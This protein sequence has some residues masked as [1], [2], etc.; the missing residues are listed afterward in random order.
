VYA[1]VTA[2]ETAPA[3]LSRQ[4]GY[5]RQQAAG[6]ERQAEQ[7]EADGDAQLA[8]D[9]RAAATEE[10]RQ[11]RELSATQDTREAWDRA[12]QAQR[13]TAR[14]ARQELDRRGIEPEPEPREPESLTGWRRQF[15][16]EAEAV[17][18]AIER[19]RQAATG[20]GQPWPPTPSAAARTPE[21]EA[22]QVIERLQRD[23]HLPGPRPERKEPQART[24]EPAQPQPE[25]EP[26]SQFGISERIDASIRRVRQAGERAAAD[27]RAQQHGRSSFAARIAQEA[28]YE[29]QT[30]QPWPSTQA[31]GRSAE[32]DHE[33]EI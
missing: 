32:A 18:R 8:S 17:E 11:A 14:A 9:S 25:P 4:L 27:A 31:G 22:Q 7:A 28:Q 33:A 13:L 30:A 29:A 19:Q 1:Y 20:A 24:P 2:A 3:D 5:H 6:L 10:T 16:A 23:G 21:L 26:G 12:H 15:Q